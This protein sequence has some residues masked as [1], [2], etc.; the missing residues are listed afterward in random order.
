[1]DMIGDENFHKKMHDIFSENGVTEHGF[2]NMKILAREKHLST[3][4]IFISNIVNEVDAV[5]LKESIVAGCI[6]LTVNYGVFLETE[7]IKFD[8]NHEEPK[9]MQRIGLEILKLM[10]DHEKVNGIR[11]EFKKSK[12]IESWDTVCEKV[13]NYIN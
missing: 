6:P 2:Q 5:K 11:E 12:T 9:V 8:M 10:R 3:F 7:G 1:M 4:H 13:Y